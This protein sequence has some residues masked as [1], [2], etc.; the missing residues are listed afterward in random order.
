MYIVTIPPARAVR[1]AADRNERR[2][3]ELVD[4]ILARVVLVGERVMVAAA[5]LAGSQTSMESRRSSDT[6]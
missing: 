6:P 3:R 1:T 2:R 5:R 4:S